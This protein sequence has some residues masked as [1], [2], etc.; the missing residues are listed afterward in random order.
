[1]LN[2]AIENVRWIADWGRQDHGVSLNRASPRRIGNV[3]IIGAGIMGTAIAAAHVQYRLPVV[4]HDIDV[5]SLDRAATR[6]AAELHRINAHF[7]PDSHRRLVRPTADLAEA[8]RCDLVVEA[9]AETLPAKLELYSRMRDHLGTQT[10]V[11]S[12]TSTI[13]LERLAHGLGVASRFCGLHFCHPVEQRPLVEI[14]RGRETSDATIVAAV[15]HAR[16]IDRM[17]MVVE[18]GPGF[19]VNRL[20]FPY[21]GEALALLREGVPAEAIERAAAE[22]GMTIGPLR[23]MDE[24]GLDTTL[25]AA[26]VL[27]AAFP[28]RIVSSPLLVALIKA[29]RLGQKT[30]C[31]FFAYR[32]QA[33]GSKSVMVDETATQRLAPWI[34]TCPQPT[35]EAISLRLVLP[36]LLEATRILEEDKVADVRD[37]DLAVLFGLG[38]PAAKGGLLWWADDLGAGRIVDLLASQTK[39][40]RRAEPTPMLR[41]MARTGGAFYGIAQKASARCPHTSGAGVASRRM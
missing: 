31:G 5:A 11:G 36:M 17:P 15:A 1:M 38:F 37:I 28:E 40:G 20:L 33:D 30:G 41:A 32:Q 18:D 27:A 12:N 22:F 4:I 19:V 39:M 13:P 3:G 21:L 16:R 9:I 8:A 14:V 24:I 10:I 6:V 23:L 35:S 26:W 25:Q 34:E 2:T 29:G 7:L